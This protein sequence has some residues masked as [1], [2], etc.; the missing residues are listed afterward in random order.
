MS[1]SLAES[2]FN[3]GLSEHEAHKK[4]QLFN[5]VEQQLSPTDSQEIMRWFVPG[6]IEVLGKHTDYGGGRSLL[7]T[8]ERGFCVAATPRTDSLVRINDLIRRQSFE[9]T[10]SPDLEIPCYGWTVYAAVVARRLARNF[11]GAT[12]GADIALASDLPSAAGMS[13]SSALVV[14]M[15]AVVS[16]I[17]RLSDRE[18]YVANIHRVEDLAGYLGCIE[19]G[20]TYQALAG[21]GGVGTF[22]GSEDHTAILASQ[23]G[24]L[25][26][27]AF[28]PVRLERTV[29]LPED[30]TFVIAVSG[31]VASKTGA[32]RAQYNRASLATRTILEVWRSI[33]GASDATLA[34]VTR[35]SPDAVD[36]LRAALRQSGSTADSEWLL[37]RFEQFRLESEVIVPQACDALGAHDL[38]TFGKLVDESQAAAEKLL[39][40][41]VPETVSLAKHAR[42]LGACAASAFG[43]G[44]GGSVWALVPSNEAAE[45]ASRW[46]DAYEHSFHSAARS[47]QFFITAAGPPLIQL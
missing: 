22:G 34:A 38:T 21:D 28:C 37:N 7:C 5:T 15:F 19:N 12:C 14:A 35:N 6:R 30:Y 33:S 24:R 45:F 44:F 25:K 18:E 11:P 16:A 17:N 26:Q 3:A 41:Q 31:V 43:A 42:A 47:I 40:N 29:E 13:S 32:A 4:A 9:F 8:A 27:Y 20:Q 46:R 1:I 2:L 10:I 23:P 36:Q 39:G